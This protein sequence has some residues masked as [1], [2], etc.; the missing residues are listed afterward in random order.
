M[1]PI[2]ILAV[3]GGFERHAQM[4]ASIGKKSVL[5]RSPRDLDGLSGLIFPGGES[6]TQLRLL[7]ATGL[8]HP[9]TSLVRGGVPI[10]A[11]CAGLVLLARTVRGPAQACL[12]IVDV[13]VTRNAWGPQAESCEATSDRGRTLVFIRAPRIEQVG[14]AVEVLDRFLG[15]PVLVRQGNV[16]CATFHPELSGNPDLHRAVFRDGLARNRTDAAAVAFSK[17]SSP[18]T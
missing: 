12:G 14:P 7:S 8:M 10:F 11:T 6:T 17:G 16:V 4:L 13:I 3:Q 1:A 9:L 15:E 5:V 18:C 2:G